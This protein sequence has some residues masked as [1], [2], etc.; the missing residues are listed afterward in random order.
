MK[1]MAGGRLYVALLLSVFAG[2]LMAQD[3]QPPQAAKKPHITRIHGQEIKDDYFW[4]REKD[5][6]EVLKYLK[7]ENDY[8]AAMMHGT[9]ALQEK[10][11]KEI[12][13]RIKEDDSNV[14]YKKG[15]YFY[16][17]RTEQG[18]Q[19]PIYCRKRGSLDAAEEITLDLNE[20]AKGKKFLSLGAYSVSDDGHWLAYSTDVTGF[21]QYALHVKDLRSGEVKASVAKRVT[22]VAWADDNRTLYYGQEDAKT[23][24][25]NKIYRFALGDAK[26]QLLF[27]ETDELYNVGV[28]KTRSNGYILVESSSSTTSE[29]RYARADQPGALLQVFLPRRDGVEYYIDHSGDQFFIRTNDQGKNF[30]LVMA[31]VNDV[32]PS[33]WREVIPHNTSVMIEGVDCFADHYIVY[34]RE[35][36][37]PGVQITR[38]GNGESHDITFSEPVYVVDGGPNAEFE[39]NLFRFSYESFITPESVFDYDVVTRQ[40]VLLKQQPVLGRYDPN[41]YRSER[42]YATAKDGVQIPISLVYRVDTSGE[43]T[44]DGKH[45]LLLDGYGSYGISNDVDFSSARLSLLDRGV[46]FAIAHIRGGGELGKDWHDHGK[47][48]SKMNTFT[49]F[50]AASEYLVKEK[51][52]SSDRLIITGG[53]A[54]G[55]LMGAVVNLRPDLFKAV[56]S[57]VP[58][59]DVMN[60][61]LDASLPLTVGEY[62]EWGNPNERAAYDYMRS[63]SPYDNLEHKAYPSI[64]MR[65]SYNDSQVMY[66]EPAKYVAKLRTLKTDSNP[67][68]F[69]IKLEPGGH[70]GASG[71]YDRIKDTAFD[72]AFMLDQLGLRE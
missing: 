17:S 11:Y 41:K 34:K 28:G 69:K 43:L 44:R 32:S 40:R 31:P 58:F 30:R 67:L 25:S 3:V 26:H 62:L 18:K 22:S 57:Q 55:L 7:A 12:L 36:G 2:V 19:Y 23:K 64:L 37:V 9:E 5:H 59:V 53:S 13:G 71:R 24:R 4:L 42:V 72:Y 6:P 50:I 39:T 61:M 8:T 51:F 68:L 27:N 60:T 63:Y 15:E 20:L 29:V 47:M 35:K 56:V 46:I 21:R 48:M 1:T 70:G 52:T 33:K 49:D 54:G 38:I 65:T 10:L 45:P 14:P 66:W 16:Y